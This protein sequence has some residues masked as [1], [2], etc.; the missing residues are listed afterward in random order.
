[1]DDLAVVQERFPDAGLEFVLG[2]GSCVAD[3]FD[4][5]V[6]DFRSEVGEA[7]GYV[8]VVPDDDERDAGERDAGDVK[9]AGGS[10]GLEIGLIPNARDV[11]GEMHVVGEERLAGGSV[12]AGDDPVVGA[13]ETTIAD[14][15]A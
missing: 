6:L 5:D 4:V 15:V 13:G 2:G 9:L 14:R 10:R 11:V 8:I 12:G 1:M 3:V 7:P